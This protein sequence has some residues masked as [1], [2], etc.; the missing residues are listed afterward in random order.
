MSDIVV[1]DALRLHSSIQLEP[2][3]GVCSQAF[4]RLTS[5]DGMRVAEGLHV[6]YKLPTYYQ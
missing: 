5:A 2:I 6:V 3:S 1:C 4:G